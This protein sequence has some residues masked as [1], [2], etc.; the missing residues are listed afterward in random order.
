M[1][2]ERR[3]GLEGQEERFLDD[4][5]RLRTIPDHS[6]GQIENRRRMSLYEQSERLGILL[7][8][9]GHEFGFVG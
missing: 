1:R 2:A 8:T 4:V 9:A 7:T 6:S 3:Q 5:F